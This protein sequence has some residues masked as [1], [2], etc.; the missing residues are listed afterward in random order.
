MRNV[1]IEWK[2]RDMKI[3]HAWL[4]EKKSDEHP[5][6]ETNRSMPYLRPSER[7]FSKK[8]CKKCKAICDMLKKEKPNIE[9]KYEDK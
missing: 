1:V 8:K 5:L 7:F 6:C 9:I 4:S 3:S 2:S